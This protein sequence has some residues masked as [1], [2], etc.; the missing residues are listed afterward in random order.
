M[1]DAVRSERLLMMLCGER[2]CF[3]V[4]WG[5]GELSLYYLAVW[6]SIGRGGREGRRGITQLVVVRVVY[7]TIC[8]TLLAG[9][10]PRLVGTIWLCPALAVFCREKEG[11]RGLQA[12]DLRTRLV[13]LEDY[14][15]K[16]I[17][18]CCCISCR[19]ALI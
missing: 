7:G 10:V 16:T 15:G 17:K 1:R 6:V 4:S 18:R 8:F 11:K 2:F 9:I 5:P 12:L 13:G 19:I 3:F 14:C